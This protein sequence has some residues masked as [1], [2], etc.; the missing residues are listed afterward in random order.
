MAIK[1][2]FIITTCV[3][4][5]LSSQIQR[6]ENGFILALDPFDLSTF[7][8]NKYYP[9]QNIDLDY[10]SII[11]DGSS[12]FP[13][14]QSIPSNIKF[15]RDDKGTISELKYKER[16]TDKYF[17]TGIS[18]KKDIND[19]TD[20]LLQAESKS[21]VDNINQNAFFDY[22]KLTKN[23]NMEVSYLYH[24]EDDP[25]VYSLVVNEDGSKENESFNYGLKVNYFKDGFSAYAHFA[26]Q[27]SNI[28][29]PF[30]LTD[31][32]A[33]RLEYNHQTIWY[34]TYVSYNLFNSLKIYFKNKYKKNLLE[35]HNDSQLLLNKH[36]NQS[37]ISLIYNIQDL[38][39]LNFGFDNYNNTTK[40]HIQITYKKD[41]VLV[42]LG[43]DNFIID[44][45]KQNEETIEFYALDFTTRYR[46]ATG[47][48]YKKIKNNF[49]FGE[50]VNDNYKYNYFVSDGITAIWKFIFDYN[51]YNYF[52]QSKGEL[53]ID[54]Y[55]NYGIS[56]YPFK[57]KY[58]FEMY[59]KINYYQYEFNSSV[60]LLSWDLFNNFNITQNNV[61]LYNLSVGFIFDSFK[62]SYNFKNGLTNQTLNNY[63]LFADNMY[64][65]GHFNYIEIDWIFKE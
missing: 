9:N 15:D 13:L 46:A 32:D 42:E 47:F 8:L 64:N 6:Q 31:P 11:L 44:Q 35:N 54:S 29:R 20:F 61:K 58:K 49:E 10:Y 27:T 28:D 5:L 14:Y 4:S 57:D 63:I 51:Y 41:K 65:F 24:Y 53:S 26:F 36:F 55:L 22:R 39:T 52:N 37:S 23:L 7:I 33:T 2:F 43:M 34:N 45:M 19:K 56:Y 60:N 62:I 3:F 21:I 59:G 18:L 30:S 1:N 16:K 48:N 12:N 40:S 25:S 50:I 38:A 17:D